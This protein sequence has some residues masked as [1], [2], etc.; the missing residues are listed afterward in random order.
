MTVKELIVQLERRKPDAQVV[1]ARDAEG[2]D[3]SPLDSWEAGW[4]TA[5]TT[6]SG[7][8]EY[9]DHEGPREYN[10]VC[11]WPVN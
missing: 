5:E 9:R 8:F 7:D 11:L 10:A 3:F 1:L 6:Y 4:Y 2:N